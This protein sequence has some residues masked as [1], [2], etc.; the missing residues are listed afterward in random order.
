MATA[1]IHG[2]SGLHISTYEN[3]H[4]KEYLLVCENFINISLSF[5]WSSAY[6]IYTSFRCNSIPNLLTIFCWWRLL[7]ATFIVLAYDL[8]L[9]VLGNTLLFSV[10]KALVQSWETLLF[11]LRFITIIIYSVA[12]IEGERRLL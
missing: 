2:L 9:L 12:V 4:A 5:Q 11:L 6:S 7:E 8:I 1:W 3:L 10:L